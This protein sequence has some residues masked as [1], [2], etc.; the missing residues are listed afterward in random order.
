MEILEAEGVARIVEFVVCVYVYQWFNSK[1]AK[2]APYNQLKLMKDI[3]AWF[4]VDPE[5][6]DLAL[7]KFL[8]HCWYLTAELT[9]LALVSDKVSQSFF[10]DLRSGK[11]MKVFPFILHSHY[12]QTLLIYIWINIA[13]CL[14]R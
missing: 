11:I 9:P 4:K 13:Q 5:I 2:D 6:A 8:K 14:S 3:C 7:H 12:K 10:G 1:K